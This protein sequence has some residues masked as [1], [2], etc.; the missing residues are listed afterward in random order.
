M[1]LELKHK[2]S[3]RVEVS[4]LS[5]AMLLLEKGVLFLNLET[6]QQTFGAPMP[7]HR[8]CHLLGKTFWSESSF[9]FQ[10]RGST[11]STQRGENNIL[12]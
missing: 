1:G 2:H 7:V 9:L 3:V 11:S 10:L 4:L 6:A 8:L 5:E 12:T